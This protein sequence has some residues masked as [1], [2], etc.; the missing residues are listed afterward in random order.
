M[1]YL[2]S[3]NLPEADVGLLAVSAAYPGI[4][5]ELEKRGIKVIPVGASALL[6]GPVQAHADMLCHP[7]GGRRIVVARREKNLLADLKQ[8]GFQ[9]KES[10]SV[11]AGSYPNDSPLNAARI[12]NKLIANS[13]ILDK[14]IRDD[15]FINRIKIVEVRQGYA[16]C[17][18][19]V[20]DE[21]SIIT[22]DHGI[23]AAASKEGIEVLKIQPGYIR[24]P[25]YS[26]GFIGGSCG[27]IGR[28]RMAFAGN[29]N[30]H[31]DFYKIKEFLDRRKIEIIALS[32][33]SLLDI[34][35]MIPLMERE[36]PI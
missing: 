4:R 3:P 34:G 14:A 29:P 8:F 24:L 7:L 5:M 22:S 35:G 27:L 6:P 13:K 11:I 16:K 12:G 17:S 9:I 10:A 26:Y 33:G 31:P 25:G 15:C 28:N 36:A 23:A 30:C 1:R 20:V 18:V 2:R 19:A 32:E 21:H